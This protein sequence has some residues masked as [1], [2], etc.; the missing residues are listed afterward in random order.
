MPFAPPMPRSFTVVSV[1]M[2]APVA[3]GVYGIS[4]AREWIYIGQAENIQAALMEH[5]GDAGTSIMNR[6][7]TGFIFEVCDLASRPARMNRLVQEYKPTCNQLA[8][9]RA[10]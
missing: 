9:G 10:W 1:R 4:N 6:R 8:E 2:N 7:P 5:L 3:P